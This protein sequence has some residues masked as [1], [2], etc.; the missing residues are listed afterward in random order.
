M[1]FIKTISIYPVLLALLLLA[2]CAGSESWQKP[3]GTQASFNLDSRECRLIGEKIALLHSETGKSV[4]PVYAARAYEECMAAKGW[5]RQQAREGA[6]PDAAAESGS[7]SLPVLAEVHGADT[8]V[9]FGQR[10][11]VPP[12]FNMLPAKKMR[13]GPTVMEQFFWQCVEDRRND[14]GTVIVIIFQENNQTSFE[15]IG[16][17]VNPPYS[18]YTSGTAAGGLL[19]WAAFWGQVKKDWVMGLGAYYHVSGNRRI[20]VV[21]TSPLGPPE[22][23]PPSNVILSREQYHQV[24]SFASQWQSWLEKQFPNGPGMVSTLKRFLTPSVK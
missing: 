6:S 3:G 1:E 10:I 23:T 22:S 9:G 19:Q 24:D 5:R 13:I 15:Q 8:L 16:Y 12:G 17:P 14:A 2:G 11:V 18:L 4:D 7:G 21:I 20:I